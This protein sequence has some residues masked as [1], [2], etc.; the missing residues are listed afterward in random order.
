MRV[1]GRE[2]ARVRMER[3]VA[4]AMAMVKE[5]RVAAARARRR[6]GWC[7]QRGCW[8]TGDRC[9]DEGDGGGEGRC[10]EGDGGGEG[11]GGDGDGGGEGGGGEREGG[12]RGDRGS[13]EG[14]GK[15]ETQATARA[16]LCVTARCVGY[17]RTA[18]RG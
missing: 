18:V 3:S 2:V 7:E 17:Y 1:E 16:R 12:A 13:G 14:E 15:A 4:A 6:T 5:R 9:S 8:R 11:G 10:G